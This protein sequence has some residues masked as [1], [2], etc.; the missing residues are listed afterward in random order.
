MQYRIK[1][2]RLKNFKCF[3]SSKYYEFILDDKKILLFSQALMD[4]ERQHF[5]MQ[6]N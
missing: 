5:L 3:D 4:L 2:V 6:L 1:S